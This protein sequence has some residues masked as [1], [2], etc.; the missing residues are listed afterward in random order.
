M[1]FGITWTTSISLWRLLDPVVSS[2]PDQ[3]IEKSAKHQEK[4]GVK[5][6]QPETPPKAA[7]ESRERSPLARRPKATT[8]SGPPKRTCFVC[9]KKRF[10]LR[11]L[12]ANFRKNQRE[13]LKAKKQAAAAAKPKGA[14][15][16]N[17][18]G[19]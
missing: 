2:L 17:Y 12:P 9:K 14:P 6:K 15:P 13:E 7:P 16:R 1:D 3:G 8:P 19:E 18:S 4:S 10:P 5:R 11:P